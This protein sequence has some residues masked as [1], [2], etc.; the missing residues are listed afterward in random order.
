MNYSNLSTDLEEFYF[1][2]NNHAGMG[3]GDDNGDGWGY[4]YS[5][6]S[7]DGGKVDFEIEGPRGGG[8]SGG[9]GGMLGA[10]GRYHSTLTQAGPLARSFGSFVKE[11]VNSYSFTATDL[12]EFSFTMII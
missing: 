4:G 5:L 3:E 10:Q 2:F 11:K 6:E 9:P 12:D 7:G 8:L 1:S